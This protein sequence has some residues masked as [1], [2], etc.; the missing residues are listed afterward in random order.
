MEE[1]G[2]HQANILI[3]FMSQLDHKLETLTHIN[4][5]KATIQAAN[6]VSTTSSTQESFNSK[7]MEQLTALTKAVAALSL[8][9]VNTSDNYPNRRD[10]RYRCCE[11]RTPL[12]PKK[13]QPDTPL[14][15]VVHTKYFWTQGHGKHGG[16][17]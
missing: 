1:A 14:D 7:M 17:D 10:G 2:Y 3:E 11:K 15:P 9:D 16:R 5:D 12:R 6:A 8:P 4:V 13:G